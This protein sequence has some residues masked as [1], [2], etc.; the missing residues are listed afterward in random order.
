MVRYLFKLKKS[1]IPDLTHETEND[2]L[3]G[4]VRLTYI[5]WMV[6]YFNIFNTHIPYYSRRLGKKTFLR[7]Y[8]KYWDKRKYRLPNVYWGKKNHPL[9]RLWVVLNDKCPLGLTKIIPEVS[10]IHQSV[11]IFHRTFQS[12]HITAYLFSRCSKFSI[13]K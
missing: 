9:T 5:I 1:Y 2:K 12:K 8:K 6:Y 11:R 13:N 4:G 7:P 3:Y 10:L